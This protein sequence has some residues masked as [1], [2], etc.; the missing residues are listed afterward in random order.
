MPATLY[1]I[2]DIADQCLRPVENCLAAVSGIIMFVAMVLTTLDATL[3]YTIG[4]PI[5]YQFYFSSNYLMVGMV[6]L[7]L[8]W[9]FRNGG[10]IRVTLLTGS[11][12]S[13]PR[14]LLYRVGLLLSALYIFMLAWTSGEYTYAAFV[15]NSVIIE[16][17]NWPVVWQWLPVPIGCGVFFLR[18]SL[19]VLGSAEELEHDEVAEAEL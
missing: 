1:R 7:C 15:K 14:I 13:A 12:P 3:R 19:L 4:H 11:L 2:R 6:T 10:Y 18:L 5:P 16:E 17:L 8:S 9:A